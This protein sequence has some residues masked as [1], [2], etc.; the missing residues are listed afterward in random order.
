MKLFH[1]IIGDLIALR[2]KDHQRW[3]VVP[4]F[5]LDLSEWTFRRIDHFTVSIVDEEN[6]MVIVFFLLK[7]ND[8]V[9][10]LRLGK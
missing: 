8:S 6:E 3:F 7:I 4:K 5:W 2:R 1:L 9:P 10:V